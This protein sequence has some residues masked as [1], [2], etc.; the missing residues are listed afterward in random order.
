MKLPFSRFS[1]LME[2]RITRVLLQVGNWNSEQMYRTHAY[3]NYHYRFKSH[4]LPDRVNKCTWHERFMSFN[5]GY[6]LL[7]FKT[8][9]AVQTLLILALIWLV[10]QKSSSHMA[11]HFFICDGLYISSSFFLP[12]QYFKFKFYQITLR[13]IKMTY[14]TEFFNLNAIILGKIN[15]IGAMLRYAYPRSFPRFL[16]IGK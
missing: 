12:Q 11:T 8:I 10:M 1:F 3:F 15:C 14:R 4:A 6:Q 5:S 16:K 7:V 2:G 13:L 9:F